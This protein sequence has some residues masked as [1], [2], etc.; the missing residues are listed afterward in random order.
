MNCVSGN[1]NSVKMC[2][3]QYKSRMMINVDMNV[4]N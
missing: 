2:V 3:T 4:N 1:V